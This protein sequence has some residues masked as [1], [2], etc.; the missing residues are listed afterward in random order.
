MGR[1]LNQLVFGQQT[2]F[3]RQNNFAELPRKC[4]R[5]RIL[6]HFGGTPI[7]GNAARGVRTGGV[8]PIWVANNNSRALPCVR[9]RGTKTQ[10]K[11]FKIL[12]LLFLTG[13]SFIFHFFIVRL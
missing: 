8:R 12:L 4:R 1:S 11:R 10:T 2:V 6:R 5:G 9:A 13:V 7:E 3:Q